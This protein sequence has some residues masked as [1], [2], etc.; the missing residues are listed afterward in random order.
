[1]RCLLVEHPDGLVLIDTALGNKEDAKF[2][3]IYGV[4]NQGLEGATQLEDALAAAG[5]LPR[6]R[7]VGDQH[8]PALRPRRRQHHARPGA[9]GR[10]PPSRPARLPQRHLRGAEG[11]AGVRPAHQRADPG[12]LPAA[13]LRAGRRGGAV[14]AAGGRRGGPAGDLGAGHAGPRALPSDGAGARQGRDRG[15]HGGPDPDHGAPAAALDH[16]IR[17]G[18]APDAGEQAGFLAEAVR[19]GWRLV[20]EHD[21]AMAMGTPVHGGKDVVLR[22]LSRPRAGGQPERNEG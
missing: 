22:E 5:F 10:S 13:Q 16:G 2:L 14:A 12:E 20:F 6:R 11:R 18:A 7:A 17:P 8:P 9:G 19:E 1:M 4:E 21:P 3:D 15:V